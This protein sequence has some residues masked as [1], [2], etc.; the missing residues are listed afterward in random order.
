MILVYLLC[1][2]SL[3]D[4]VPKERLDEHIILGLVC[5]IV[6]FVYQSRDASAGLQDKK[7]SSWNCR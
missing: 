7:T 5:Y 4:A 2:P 6:Q 3:V 1:I